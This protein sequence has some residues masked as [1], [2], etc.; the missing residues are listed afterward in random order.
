MSDNK[1]D[2]IKINMKTHLKS[3][4]IENVRKQQLTYVNFGMRF[5]IKVCMA[6]IQHMRRDLHKKFR[7]HKI[8]LHQ[9]DQHMQSNR[10]SLNNIS[11]LFTWKLKNHP[12]GSLD[13]IPNPDK[14]M[15]HTLGNA[16]A[17][18]RCCVRRQ[19]F[20]TT[21]E[22]AHNSPHFTKNPVVEKLLPVVVA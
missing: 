19:C 4:K 7:S 13:F 9:E 3:T 20:R 22:T 17:F 2:L 21:A 6:S 10:R 18:N 16:V 11:P 1:K 14:I 5:I 15:P 8:T 12:S